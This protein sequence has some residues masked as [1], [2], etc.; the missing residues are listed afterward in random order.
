M[1]PANGQG[2]DEWQKLGGFHQPFNSASSSTD[3]VERCPED[4]DDDRQTDHDLGGGHHQHEEHRD[5]TVDQT[6]RPP[7]RHEG[8]VHGVE[9]QL[10]AHEHDEGVAPHQD[11]EQ[12]DGEQHRSQGHV[13]AGSDGP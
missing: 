3:A 4:G 7:G 5:L 11:A 1:A 9:H 12:A 6:Q 2:D 13:P 10:D 8:E